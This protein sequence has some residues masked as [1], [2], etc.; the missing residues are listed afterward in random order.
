MRGK[1]MRKPA[2]SPWSLSQ[3]EIA[4]SLWPLDQ[5]IP[6]DRISSSIP[7]IFLQFLHF[8]NA[9]LPTILCETLALLQNSLYSVQEYSPYNVFYVKLYLYIRKCRTVFVFV[10]NTTFFLQK[11]ARAVYTLMFHSTSKQTLNPHPLLNYPV[12]FIF[13]LTRFCVLSFFS[14]QFT[15]LDHHLYCQNFSLFFYVAL[16]HIIKDDG[17]YMT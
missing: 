11:C 7:F 16:W 1:Q 9:R 12:S 6:A 10:F 17:K 8:N 3:L 15:L 2:A 4:L 5:K 14:V 13:T